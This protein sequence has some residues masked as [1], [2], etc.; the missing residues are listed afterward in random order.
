MF[1]NLQ[2]IKPKPNLE[3]TV[4][5]LS[6]IQSTSSETLQ[7]LSEKPTSVVGTLFRINP[8][9]LW[10]DNKNIS[11][12]M[13]PILLQDKQNINSNINLIKE[14]LTENLKGHPER[15]MNWL[16]S[17]QS[18][19][20]TIT[21]SEDF[22]GIDSD[23]LTEIG[24]LVQVFGPTPNDYF[25]MS[26]RENGKEF[27]LGSYNQFAETNSIANRNG[28][29][30]EKCIPI[31]LLEK[32]EEIGMN[33][34][35][36]FVPISGSRGTY[37][38]IALSN[39]AKEPHFLQAIKPV[40]VNLPT[41][42]EN[43]NKINANV[44][45]MLGSISNFDS[46]GE[47]T[48]NNAEFFEITGSMS[49]VTIRS[50][51]NNSD[52]N[53][54]PQKGYFGI[55]TYKDTAGDKKLISVS[56][57]NESKTISIRRITPLEKELFT[58]KNYT[59]IPVIFYMS[60]LE[61][62]SNQ[63]IDAATKTTKADLLV[64]T[65]ANFLSQ[66]LD[67]NNLQ[68]RASAIEKGIDKIVSDAKTKTYGLA[69]ILKYIAIDKRLSKSDIN[70][71]GIDFSADAISTLEKLYKLAAKS[72]QTNDSNQTA[73]SSNIKKTTL[74][75]LLNPEADQN[76]A[77]WASI[78]KLIKPSV[79]DPIIKDD[80]TKNLKI[81]TWLENIAKYMLVETTPTPA[82]IKIGEDFKIINIDRT[83]LKEDL[84]LAEAKNI[85]NALTSLKI[86]SEHKLI[87]TVNQLLEAL[88]ITQISP[89]PAT[90][91]TTDSTWKSYK[92]VQKLAIVDQ[93]LNT[94]LADDK[95]KPFV[96]DDETIIIINTDEDIKRL[97]NLALDIISTVTDEAITKEFS[98]KT[99]PTKIDSAK[100]DTY[101]KYRDRLRSWFTDSSKITKTFSLS[102]FSMPTLFDINQPSYQ[103]PVAQK[104]F[105][106]TQVA[107]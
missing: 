12:V 104:S 47:T 87:N 98:D 28:I 92:V 75:N 99:D 84:S 42:A 34:V 77:L 25:I 13:I 70:P 39:A 48:S 20:K 68:Y 52:I 78:E 61:L 91:T 79:S 80:A 64:S 106:T 33:A 30:I 36:R 93:A 82:G 60:L 4:V 38:I 19:L 62:L 69:D 26:I 37:G 103:A 95:D 66:K 6:N 49:E 43:A 22:K 7:L 45:L 8:D 46:S 10:L 44:S 2:T 100:V 18:L 16:P 31:Q 11:D 83:T 86:F 56:T 81:M 41:S 27:I 102:N 35:F 53:F 63:N 67:E 29:S 3:K 90:P 32:G 88:G 74:N 40:E 101:K 51:A 1:V 72:S 97:K 50:A 59:Q 76:L 24:S 21:F 94:T 15:S 23:S 105:V 65:F 96:V 54:S 9:S 71:T 85:G 89:T 5:S 57:E 55:S 14:F 73:I 107:E 58:T 17:I